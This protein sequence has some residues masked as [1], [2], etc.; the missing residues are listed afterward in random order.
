MKE[1]KL[2]RGKIALVDDDIYD[3]INQWNWYYDGCYAVRHCRTNKKS[4]RIFMHRE[5]LRTPSDMETDHINGN[6]IDNRLI[7]LRICEH[8]QNG[9][10]KKLPTNNTSGYKGVCW[11]LR[12]NKWQA[13]IKCRGERYFLGFYG[14]INDAI[15]AYNNKAKELFG[16]FMRDN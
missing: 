2:T 6:G 11:S 13:Y 1:I 8:F 5:I 10:N 12:M 3:Y 16:E 14:D 4:Q 7:N 9:A 15:S